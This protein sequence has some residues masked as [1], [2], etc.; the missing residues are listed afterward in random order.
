VPRRYARVVLALSIGLL[1]SDFMSRQ[2]LNAVF[3]LLKAQWPLSDA[4]LGSLSSVV[5]LTV[6]VLAFPLSLLADRWDR[7]KILVLAAVTWSLATVAC[8]LAADYGQM[9]LARTFVGAGE[10]AYGSVGIA[11]VLSVF[12]VARRATLAGTFLAGGAFG[13]VLGVAIGGAVGQALGWRWAFGVMGAFGLVLAVIYGLVVTERRLGPGRVAA[14]ARAATRAPLRQLF[15]RVSLV[16]AYVGSGLQFIVVG[17]LVAWLPSF[18]NRYYHL[19]IARAG[20]LAGLFA[21]VIGIGMIGGGVVGDRVGPAAPARKW[22]VAITC[23]LASCALLLAAFWL[24]AGGAQVLLLAFGALVSAATAG[25]AGAMVANLAPAGLS[26]SAFAVLALANNLLGLA[27]G[28][29]LTGVLADRLGLI[30]ALRLI[31]L[32]AVGAAI[33]FWVGRLSVLPAPRAP[34]PRPLACRGT[35]S[36]P[37][38]R[39]SSPARTP[40][41]AGRSRSGCR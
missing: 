11:V 19:T 33:A 6:G 12:P 9:L 31:P 5:A 3:P 10:A 37:R 32:A 39:R 36:G 22:T 26:A 20:A 29:A 41:R 34:R 4:R 2:V 28:S 21:L 23:S 13:T 1:L 7:V 14:G 16:S 8:G 17:A 40:G 35:G 15:S 24:P 30:G 27:P 38:G 18:F 25:P